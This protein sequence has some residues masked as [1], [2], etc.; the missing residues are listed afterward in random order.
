MMGYL[1]LY[2]LESARAGCLNVVKVQGEQHQ[3]SSGCSSGRDDHQ[4]RMVY[5]DLPG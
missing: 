5:G 2:V 4:V 1:H 3:A